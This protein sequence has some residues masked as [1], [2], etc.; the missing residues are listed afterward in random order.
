MHSLSKLALSGMTLCLASQLTFAQSSKEHKC[1]GANSCKGMA[2]QTEKKAEHSCK[3]KSSCKGEKAEHSCKAS[4]SCK[5]EK[6]EHSCKASA[7]CKGM[8]K[9]T[10]NQKSEASGCNSKSG[11]GAAPVK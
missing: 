5:G 4:A 3:A 2:Q 10:T 11:C 9:D 1:G 8:S 6:A 7:S